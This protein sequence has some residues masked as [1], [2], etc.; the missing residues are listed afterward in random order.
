[1]KNEIRDE[2]LRRML[3]EADPSGDDAG[4]T[5]EEVRDMRRTVLRAIPE[6]SRRWVLSPLLAGVVMAALFA[7]AVLMLWPR[8]ESAPPTPPAPP[9]IA[10]KEPV[11]DVKSTDKKSTDVNHRTKAVAAGLRARRPEASAPGG[12]QTR[13]PRRSPT[14]E[15]DR[16]AAVEEPRTRQIQFDTPGGTRVIW[17]LTSNNAL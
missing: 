5:M 16:I 10:V 6:T 11:T 15:P 7:M 1:M 9:R 8:S 12:K 2:R 14:K 17:I 3:R 13:P 4:L